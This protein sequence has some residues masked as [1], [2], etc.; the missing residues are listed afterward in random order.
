[1]SNSTFTV[2]IYSH[3]KLSSKEAS[4][5]IAT[6]YPPTAVIYSQKLQVTPHLG[7]IIYFIRTI[8]VE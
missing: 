1:M 7:Q 3:E 4:K 8:A 5:E 6:T 2:V